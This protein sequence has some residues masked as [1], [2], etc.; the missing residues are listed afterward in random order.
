MVI[1]TVQ[2]KAM[3][4]V[5]K[6][7]YAFVVVA[8]GMLLMLCPFDF[9]DVESSAATTAQTQSQN[10][11]A[12]EKRL[13][14]VLSKIEGAG[15][16]SVLLME[17]RGEEIIYQTNDYTTDDTDK[18]DTVTVTDSDRNQ[19][20]LVKQVL[21]AQYSGAIVVCEGADDPQIRLLLTD[22]VAKITGLGVNRITVLKMK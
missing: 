16:V 21:P 22:A 5:K 7:K 17:A 20:G 4:F 14:Q 11:E 8:I 18:A 1:K 6:N 19:N 2:A 3:D 12:V 10:V 9:A 13:A 15:D